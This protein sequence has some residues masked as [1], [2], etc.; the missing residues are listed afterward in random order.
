MQFRRALSHAVLIVLLA[1]ALSG[2]GRRG[3]L[4]PPPDETVRPAAPGQLLSGPTEAPV[5]EKKAEHPFV[6]DPLLD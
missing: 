2:C 5:Q 1:A 4:E 6:L 3:A